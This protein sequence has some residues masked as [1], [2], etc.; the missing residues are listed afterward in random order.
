LAPY[1]I[2]AAV[3]CLVCGFWDMPQIR[4]YAAVMGGIALGMAAGPLIARSS[5]SATPVA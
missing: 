3:T 1:L 4:S 5:G 2:A